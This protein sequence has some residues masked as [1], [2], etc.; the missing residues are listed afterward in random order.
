M[1][2][3]HLCRDTIKKFYFI[4]LAYSNFNFNLNIRSSLLLHHSAFLEFLTTFVASVL[5]ISAR[6]FAFNFWH[7][8]KVSCWQVGYRR[9]SRYVWFLLAYSLSHFIATFKVIVFF[10]CWLYFFLVHAVSSGINRC[11]H[12]LFICAWI[13]HTKQ[14]K[15]TLVYTLLSSE[16]NCLWRFRQ[17]WQQQQQQTSGKIF[18]LWSRSALCSLLK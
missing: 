12:C 7:V 11:L 1:I 4:F 15:P 8:V 18:C 2:T 5:T 3:R 17:A 10:F 6:R 9:L 14:P 16:L 13:A